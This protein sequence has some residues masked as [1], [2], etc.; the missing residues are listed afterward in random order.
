MNFIDYS[1]KLKIGFNDVNKLQMLKNKISNILKRN[2]PHIYI[3]IDDIF[4]FYQ[5]LGCEFDDTFYS[6]N[7]EYAVLVKLDDA[8]SLKK[9]ISIY[10]AFVNTFRNKP[11]I[12]YSNRKY[13]CN[14]L[15]DTLID[16]K[17]PFEL[18]RDGKEYYLFPKGAEELDDTLVS[19]PLS[20]LE[21]YPTAHKTFVVAL[22]QYADGVFIRDVADNFRKSLEDFLKEFFSNTKNYSN[23]ISEVGNFLKSAGLDSEIT[24]IYVNLCKA[25]DTLNNKVAKHNDMVEPIYL[26]FLMYQTGLF[27][28]MLIVVKNSGNLIPL[29]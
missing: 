5:M 4:L 29:K 19:Q 11:Q 25:Y 9:Y 27:I 28:R 24:N 17:I 20:W 14:M 6:D 7:L 23:N 1:E 12:K 18:K 2:V 3:D 15:T 13:L 26:E 8:Y 10:I 16:L 21:D 22:R